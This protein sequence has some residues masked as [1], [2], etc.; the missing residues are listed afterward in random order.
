MRGLKRGLLLA[1][2]VI[3][4]I[5]PSAASA[6]DLQPADPPLSIQ[7]GRAISFGAIAPEHVAGKSFTRLHQMGNYGLTGIAGE[8]GE[9]YMLV[10][11]GGPGN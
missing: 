4:G 6:A 10:F 1:G 3:G 8:K 7:V 2:L 9:G 5:G 11:R